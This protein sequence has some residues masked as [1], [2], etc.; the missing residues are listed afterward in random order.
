MQRNNS[1]Q[2]HSYKLSIKKYRYFNC[3][4][5]TWIN[6]EFDRIP[7]SALRGILLAFRLAIADLAREINFHRASV[8]FPSRIPSRV[9]QSP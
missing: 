2:S 1:T 5:S 9:Y 8:L 4:Q 7:I 3:S 6:S